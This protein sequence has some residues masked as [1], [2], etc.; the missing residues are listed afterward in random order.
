MV[1]FIVQLRVCVSP[2][3]EMGGLG[4]EL[5]VLLPTLGET[6][7]TAGPGVNVL[8]IQLK[9]NLTSKQ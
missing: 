7:D 6:K 3:Q 5:T 4:G 9:T 2:Q 1:P 8:N